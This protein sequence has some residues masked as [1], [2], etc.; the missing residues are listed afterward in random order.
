[1]AAL[2][3]DVKERTIV[4]NG[5]SKSYAVAGWRIGYSLAPANITT[6]M[7]NYVSHSTAAP[8]T[9]S[10]WAAVEALTGPQNTVEEMRQAF[11]TRR[12]FHGRAGQQHRRSQLF[13][14]RGCVLHHDEHQQ[15]PRPQH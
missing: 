10:Q 2:G 13:D 3:E 8:S 12:D 7:G 15:D 14:A 9:L 6:I 5:V 4:I 11:E 1:M